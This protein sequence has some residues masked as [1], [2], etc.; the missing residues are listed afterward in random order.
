MFFLEK[1]SQLSSI[2]NVDMDTSHISGTDNVEADQLSRCDF[3]S[4][5]PPKFTNPFR[6]R[7]SLQD[8]WMIKSPV[9]VLVHFVLQGSSL[10]LL[11]FWFKDFHLYV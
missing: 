8:L 9:S 5:L 10:F 3:Q 2:L 6:V 4:P 11:P 1:I 7:I